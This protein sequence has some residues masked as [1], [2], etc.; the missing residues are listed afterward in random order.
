MMTTRCASTCS[1]RSVVRSRGGQLKNDK[2]KND[3]PQHN[4]SRV[5]GAYLYLRVLWQGGWERLARVQL[6]ES[7]IR[8]CVQPM[9]RAS[10][11]GEL[12]MCAHAHLL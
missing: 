6:H 1:Q 3:N 8:P 7:H 12:G 2:S 11:K 4:I 5:Q 10:E 9:R